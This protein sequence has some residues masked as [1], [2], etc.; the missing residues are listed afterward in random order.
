M[1]VIVV[2]MIT[3]VLVMVLSG[4][5]LFLF[6]KDVFGHLWWFPL[7]KEFCNVEIVVHAIF[8]SNNI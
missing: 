8:F 1:F 4:F 5:F 2:V 3:L 6:F 7:F